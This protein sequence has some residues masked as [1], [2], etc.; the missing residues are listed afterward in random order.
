MADNEVDAGM[1]MEGEEAI[2]PIM[3]AVCAA[4][5]SGELAVLTEL[6]GNGL[7]VNAHGEDGDTALHIASLYGQ[8]AVVRECLQRGARPQEVDEDGSTALHDACASGFCA[9]V[10]LLLVAGASAALQDSD[11]DTPLHLGV[12]P[13]HTVRP[14]SHRTA[15]AGAVL[16]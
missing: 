3:A 9:I 1:E 6:W 5:E 15:T 13:E 2:D 12:R 10:E 4:A 16:R 7:D 8:E 14:R 11:G